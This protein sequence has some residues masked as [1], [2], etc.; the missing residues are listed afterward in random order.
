MYK[1]NMDGL[2]ISLDSKLIKYHSV[3]KDILKKS[4][5]NNF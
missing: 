2:Y 5:A 4:N 3:E 1:L